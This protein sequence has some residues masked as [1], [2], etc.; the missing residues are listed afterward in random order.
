M[1]SG[2]KEHLREEKNPLYFMNEQQ[3]I[4]ADIEK[5]RPRMLREIL[6]SEVK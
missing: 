3:C 4:T 6:L 5:R 1:N 2:Y